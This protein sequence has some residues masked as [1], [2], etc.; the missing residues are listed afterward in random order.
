MPSSFARVGAGIVARYSSTVPGGL[1][2]TASRFLTWPRWRGEIRDE[3]VHVQPEGAGPRAR[4]AGPDRGRPCD[5]ARGADAA[6]VLHRRRPGA[7]ARRIPALRRR[8]PRAGASP[9]GRAGFLRLR[10]ARQDGARETR[11]RGSGRMVRAARLLL[12]EPGR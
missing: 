12:L 6:V 2:F 8:S 11:R 10:A 7:R 9:A 5:P 3:A 1:V 4:L